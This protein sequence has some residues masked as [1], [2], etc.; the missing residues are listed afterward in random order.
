VIPLLNWLETPYQPVPLNSSF[1]IQRYSH[2]SRHYTIESLCYEAIAQPTALLRIKAPRKMGKTSLLD[3]ILA[4]A[5]SYSYHTV[6]LNLQD[7]DE[8]KFNNI[9]NFLRWFC[10]YISQEL[11]LQN[12]VK[13][14]WQKYPMGS[15]INCKIYL[16]NY[17][18]KQL[19]KPLVL[20]LDEVDRVFN[21]PEITTEFLSLLRSCYEE[22]N[23]HNIWEKLR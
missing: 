23:N 2:Q 3:R 13:D 8:K 16:Q 1:Y 5:R 14:F 18:L 12:C 9:D 22:A 19:N 17:L 20:A 15:K 4:Q 6:R 11:D 7:I 21:Y 10:A